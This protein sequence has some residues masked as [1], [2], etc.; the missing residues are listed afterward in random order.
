MKEIKNINSTRVDQRTV[1][2]LTELLT[3]AQAGDLQ[4]LMFVDKYYNGDVGYGW[5]GT[6]DDKMVGRLEKLKVEYLINSLGVGTD[7]DSP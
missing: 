2:T 7:E 6:P 1:D 4:S 5:S 3:S